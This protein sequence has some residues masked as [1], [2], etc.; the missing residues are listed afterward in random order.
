MNHKDSVVAVGH[1]DLVVRALP[2]SKFE[3]RGIGK[4]GSN[5]IEGVA[6]ARSE[7]QGHLRLGPGR[8]KGPRLRKQWSLLERTWTEPRK[9]L[10]FWV[11][12]NM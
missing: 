4:K 3:A 1:G 8:V 6:P 5:P 12:A 7:S 2:L 11:L 10:C 9:A